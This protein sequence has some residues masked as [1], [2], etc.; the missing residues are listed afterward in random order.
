MNRIAS[1]AGLAA[2]AFLIAPAA[3]AQM[4][5]E[6]LD[7][8]LTAM[9]AVSSDYLFRGISQTR[10][11]PAIQG[12]FEALHDS[13][14]YA[15]AFISNVAF[16]GTDARQELDLLAGYRFE[17]IGIA[18]DIGA[19]YYSYPGYSRPSSGYNIDY[20][21]GALKASKAIGTVTLVGGAY[22]SPN[23]FGQSGTSLYL[24][25][26]ADVTL[27]LGFTASGR[28]GYQ[29]IEHE[30]RFGTPDYA[31][32]SASISREVVAGVTLG[33]GYYGTD[34]SQDRCSGRQKVC[35]DRVMVTLSRKF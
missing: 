3:S 24:E 28:F 12:T 18:W 13:G 30:P 1:A 10:N 9:P 6:A 25:G 15:G 35:D 8:T 34:I 4:R 14:F 27:P 32:W 11:R 2:A 21:E 31:T 5:V 33:V 19:I 29:W 20:I 7:L 26:G 22:A 16:A 17:A 23:F